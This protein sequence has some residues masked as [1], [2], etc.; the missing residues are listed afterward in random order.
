MSFSV[1]NTVADVTTIG[2]LAQ[3]LSL[4]RT[5]TLSFTLIAP[6][7]VNIPLSMGTIKQASLAGIHLNLINTN[8]ISTGTAN[9]TINLK[10]G[11]TAG[12]VARGLQKALGLV[13]PGDIAVIRFYTFRDLAD[14]EVINITSNDPSVSGSPSILFNS[15]FP[16]GMA[17]VSFIA[18][19][20]TPGAETITMLTRHAFLT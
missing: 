20:T 1:S 2:P 8:G 4:Q 17:F 10:A 19:S 15:T 18:G 11:A 5:G 12:G 13:L 14:A 16:S 6:P 3:D 9:L 7:G